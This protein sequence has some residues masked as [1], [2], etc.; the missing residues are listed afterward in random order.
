LFARSADWFVASM[1]ALQGRSNGFLSAVED[2]LLAGY[3]AGA[4]AAVGTVGVTSL[5]DALDQMTYVSDTARATF[6]AAWADP[7][8][9]DPTILVR[10]VLE[11]PVAWRFAWARP[12][13]AALP[14]SLQPVVC[15]LGSSAEAKARRHLLS[16]AVDARAR[17]ALMR[18]AKFFPASMRYD[19]VNSVIGSAPWNHELGDALEASFRMSV[20]NDLSMALSAQ[21]VVPLVPAIFR[22]SDASCSAIER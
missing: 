9:L 5:L 17:G 4:P 16:L 6:A 3:A 15:S 18:R 8:T 21:G 20:V 7:E 14:S 2:P 19:W 11:T 1:L 13:R 12:N 10:R 22:S